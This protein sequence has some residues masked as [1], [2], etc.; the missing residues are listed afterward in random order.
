MLGNE[1]TVVSKIN[2]IVSFMGLINWWGREINQ[3]I[4]IMMKS[5]KKIT[6]KNIKFYESASLGGPYQSIYFPIYQYLYIFT[7]NDI[8][9]GE[10]NIWN[11]LTY[12]MWN[13]YLNK[14]GCFG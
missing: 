10:G 3:V 5:K 8:L 14:G 13:T 6:K 7:G 4:H 9:G 1:G 12:N 11:M 2:M